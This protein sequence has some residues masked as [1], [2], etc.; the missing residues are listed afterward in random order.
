MYDTK[1]KKVQYDR[2]NSVASVGNTQ[3]YAATTAAHTLGFMYMAYFFRFRRV[4]LLPAFAIASGYYYVFSKVNNSAYKWFVDRPIIQTARDI[5]LGGYV[6]PTG[7][8]RNRG[9]N[10]K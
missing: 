2:L 6:Q 10:F 1:A 9:Y 7:H 3:F 5:G 4:G 8:F